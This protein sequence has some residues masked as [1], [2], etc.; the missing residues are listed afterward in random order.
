MT[1]TLMALKIFK[2]TF[3]FVYILQN[4][5]SSEW[6]YIYIFLITICELM[7]SLLQ[8][9]LCNWSAEYR[10]TQDTGYKWKSKA[11]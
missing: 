7:G 8:I 1:Q 2:L 4:T 9:Q 3:L 11:A 5:F 10:I 6:Q